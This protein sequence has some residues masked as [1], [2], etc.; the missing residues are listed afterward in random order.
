[1]YIIIK[2]LKYAK[3]LWPYYIGVTVSSIL[4]ALTGVAIPFVLAAATNLMVDVVQGGQANVS[5][6]LWLA[7]ALFGFD[8]ANTFIRNYGGYLGDIMSVKLK[9]QLS[10]RYY[11]HLLKLPQSYYDGELTG[12]IINRLNRAI[13]EVSN[14]LNMFANNFF[15]MLLT[16]VITLVIVWFY[17]WELAL[18]IIIIYP[19]FLWLTALTS[20]RWQKLQTEKNL[21][22]DIASGRFAE[23][24]TQ[25]KVVKSYV[26]EKLEHRHFRRRYHKTVVLTRSQSKY[27]HAMDVVRGTVLSIIF[28][29][30]FAFIFVQT[31]ERNFT[32]GEMVLLITLINALRLPLFSMSFIVDQFQRAITGAKDYVVAM[33]LSPEIRDK[34]QAHNLKVDQGRIVYEGVEF[35]YSEDRA[36]LKNVSFA[37]E[38]GEKVALVGESG[39]G[40]TTLSNLLMRLYEP[41]GG[42]ITID[43]VNINDVTQVSL[44][45]QIATVF[46]DPAL[47]SGTIRENI[48]YA[49]PRATHEQIVAAA[50]AANAH[51]F[52]EKL[53]HGY[54]SEIGER[55]IKLSGGQKQRVAIARAILKDAPILILDEATSSLDSRAEH[56]VQEALDRLMKGRTTLIIAHRLS[57]IAHVDKIVTIKNGTVDEVGLPS[58]LAQTD[59]IYAQLLQLQMGTTEAAKKK[60]KTFDI[61]L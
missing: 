50:R 38:P 56:L 28:F 4:V 3:K 6:A 39:E 32:I 19:L 35:G 55:G 13:T 60:L 44:R 14:F 57:T 40:K 2:T 1:M 33:E 7:F 17:S 61:S 22:T 8:I 5:G 25:I 59:G 46:Q 42:T 37:I 16:T 49:H 21:E 48:A 27:W 20:K 36:I 41:Q 30:I 47:F 34:P 54:D 29:L 9:A 43:N 52:I 31:V 11:E 53:E 51:S 26:Q 18:L 15:Q 23:V 24:V 45:S 58:E 10:T 12:T